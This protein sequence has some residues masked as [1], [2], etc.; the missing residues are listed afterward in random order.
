[1]SQAITSATPATPATPATLTMSAIRKALPDYFGRDAVSDAKAL[2]D[3]NQKYAPLCAT[4]AGYAIERAQSGN[5]NGLSKFDA[6]SATLKHAQG[7]KLRAL[8]AYVQGVKPAHLKSADIADYEDFAQACEVAMLALVAPAPA[9]PK[10]ATI[11]WK[12]EAGNLAAALA[13]VTAERDT[14]AAELA[15]MRKRTVT[16]STMSD[17]AQALGID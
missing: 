4:L 16:L 13:V 8:V 10:A 5:A 15:D 17:T 1:M 6:Y 14:L 7:S 11:N 12:Q 9:K 3:R 2:I